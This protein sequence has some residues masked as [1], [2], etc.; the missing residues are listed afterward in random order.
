M[1]DTTRKFKVENPPLKSRKS[2]PRRNSSSV[3]KYWPKY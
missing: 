2:L 1:Y 3:G